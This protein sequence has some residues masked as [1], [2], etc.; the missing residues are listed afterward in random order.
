MLVPQGLTYRDAVKLLGGTG[1]LVRIADNLLGGALSVAIAGGS[2]AALSLF[3]A[4][5]EAIRLGHEV[6]GRITDLV[7]GNGRYT[8][9]QRLQ[10]AHGVLAVTAFFEVLQEGLDLAG[11]DMPA[12]TRDEQVRL[13]GSGPADGSWRPVLMSGYIPCPSPDVR[14]DR[15]VTDLGTWFTT[16]AFGIEQYLHGLAAWDDAAE[17]SRRVFGEWLTGRLA[18]LTVARYEEHLRRL[19]EELPEFAISPPT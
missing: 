11:L 10:A 6:A 8:R 13:A 18:E 17:H 4:K 19:A 1:P 5:A 16:V 9:S 14:Y 15:L 12:L 2:D 3:D 7:R